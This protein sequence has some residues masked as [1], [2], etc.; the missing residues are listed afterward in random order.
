MNNLKEMRNWKR[1]KN[2]LTQNRERTRS[3]WKGS[4][5]REK[6][7]VVYQVIIREKNYEIT[8]MPYYQN[9]RFSHYAEME[10]KLGGS[11]LETKLYHQKKN[12]IFMA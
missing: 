12:T 2:T 10:T 4:R 5:V 9:K 3:N 7:S 6:S 11:Y 1:G 8:K